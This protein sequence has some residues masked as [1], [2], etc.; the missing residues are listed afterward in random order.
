MTTAAPTCVK[1]IA[2]PCPF[3][4][5]ENAGVAVNLLCLDDDDAQFECKECGK[6]F[7]RNQVAD[8]IRRWSRLLAWIDQAPDMDAE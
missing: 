2:M 6:E 5:E 7:G 3:C 8:I 4:G 1:A